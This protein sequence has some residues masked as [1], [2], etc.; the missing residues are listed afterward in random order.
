MLKRHFGSVA[1]LCVLAGGVTGCGNEDNSVTYG[2]AQITPTTA[3]TPV[4]NSRTI[5]VP[6]QGGTVQLPSTD[7]ISGTATFAPGAS[8]NTQLTVSLSE[9]PPA[10][11]LAGTT[12]LLPAA[13]YSRTG[14]IYVS[15]TVNQPFDLACSRR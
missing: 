3:S 13:G 2:S 12:T 11:A 1:L 9:T 5:I 6:P 15:V 4:Q 10:N 14:F 7:E 8:P